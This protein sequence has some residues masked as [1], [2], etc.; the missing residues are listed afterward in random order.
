MK[1]EIGPGSGRIDS[2]WTTIGPYKSNNIDIVSRWGDD[3]LPLEDC[4]V[5]I[6]YASHVLEHIWW[7]KTVDALK[8]V[9][10][11][12]R[13]GG[14]F[15]VH[16]PDFSV[17]VNSYRNKQC[18]D[19]WRANNPDGNYMLWV[20]GRIFTYGGPGN[21]HRAAFDQAHLTACLIDAGFTNISKGAVI[22]GHNHGK[23]N[24]GMTAIK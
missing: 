17:I 22:R 3:K 15:E 9:Y 20:N 12:L 11:I 10:R 18:G 2:T 4:S 5:D 23:I 7:Y 16:V 6:V 24:L 13:V 19:T 14:T 1:V 21:T 8:E